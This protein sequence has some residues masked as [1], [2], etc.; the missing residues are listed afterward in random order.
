MTYQGYENP[1]AVERRKALADALMARTLTQ[2]P[3]NVGEGLAA[4]GKA[5]MYRQMMGGIEGAEA[6]GKASAAESFAGMFFPPAPSMDSTPSM[7]GAMPSPGSPDM[8]FSGGKQG[9][10][11]MMLPSA[12]EASQRTG[13][14]PR[15]IVAQAAQETGW[16]KSAPGNNFFGI[17]SHGQGGGQNLATHEYVDGKRVNV[18]DSFR[19]FG[20]PEESVAGYADFILQNPRYKPMMQAQGMDAQLAALGQ[21]GYA[22]DPNYATSVGQI[23]RSIPFEGGQPETIAAMQAQASGINPADPSTIPVMAG[24]TMGARPPGGPTMPELAN[25][26]SN[27]WLSRGQQRIAEALMERKIAPQSLVNAGGGNLYDPNSGNWI[28]AP[29]SGADAP[30]VKQFYDDNGN[31]YM[32]EWNSQTR[33]W[34][35]VGGSKAPSGM[36]LRTNPDGSVEF[37]QG[38]GAGKLSETQSKS[39]TYATRA[40]G[41]LPVL[42]EFGSALTS[43]YQRA[44][45]GDP[46]GILR[47]TQSPEF[48]KAQQAGNEFLQAILRKDTGAAITD[49]EMDSYG[50]TYL[51]TPGDGPEVLA[52]K[53]AARKRALEALKAGM[54]PQ[55]ILAQERAL[56]NSDAAPGTVPARERKNRTKSGVSWEIE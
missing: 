43:P 9:F 39:A 26:L 3:K 13:I 51:P 37:V 6:A 34:D 52:Q 8:D 23:A 47:G 1:E 27:P 42:D 41:S 56:K 25:V 28:Q 33:A 49:S 16:G 15:I 36:S 32:A 46:T 22:T 50:R 11:D 7:S 31:P 30:T 53:Q 21:S 17:K 35:R 29:N 24:G 45:E 54:E 38:P 48:Q 5:L 10:I 20:S 55:A 40:E 2:Q 44:V 19:T 12:M 4:I 18:N 14:D